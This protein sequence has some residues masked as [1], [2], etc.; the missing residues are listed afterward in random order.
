MAPIDDASLV[1]VSDFPVVTYSGML[2]GVLAGQYDPEQMEIDL[3]RL[4]TVNGARLIVDRVTGIDTVHRELHFAERPALRYDWMSI[5]IGS[6]PTTG[7]VAIN[8]PNQILRIK[9][10]QTFLPRLGEALDRALEIGDENPA[11]NVVGGGVGGIEVALCGWQ[12]IKSIAGS[13][14]RMRIICGS[15]LGKGLL[16]DT[17]RH[18]REQMDQLGIEVFENQRVASVES[19]G[20]VLADGTRLESV[21]SLWATGAEASD[22]LRTINL[23]HDERGFLTTRPT[24]QS[25]DDDRVF[26]VGDSG[27]IQTDRTD[28]AGVFAVRQG[29]VLWRNLRHSVASAPLE[30]YWPQRGYLK[31]INLGDGRAIAEYKGVSLAGRWPWRLKDWIDRRFMAKYQ[32]YRPM[33][34]K[35]A[36][37]RSGDSESRIMRCLGCGGKIG[38]QSLRNVLARLSLRQNDRVLTGLQQADDAAVVRIE[39]GEATVTTDFLAAPFD[40]PFVN[41]R[42]AA[43]NSASD[44]LSM[45]ARPTAALTIAQIPFGHPRAQADVLAELIAG[46]AYEFNLMDV[47]IVGGHTIE[48]PRLVVGFTVFGEQLSQVTRKGNLK[49]GDQIVLTRPLGTGI[50]LAALMQG[51]CRARWYMALLETMLAGNRIALSLVEQFGINAMTDVTGFGLGGHLMEMLDASRLAAELDLDEIPVLPGVD[52]LLAEGIEST[53]APE[54]REMAIGMPFDPSTSGHERILFDPQTAGGLLFG[55]DSSRVQSV[56]EF[57]HSSGLPHSRRIGQAIPLESGDSPCIILPPVRERTYSRRPE[58]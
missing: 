3:V 21:F 9:P 36:K 56:L 24:L 27:T 16:P 53:L 57:L 2:P 12:R 50:L 13:R 29:P 28:K 42:I 51:K 10:M 34:R 47:S 6:R 38:G 32:D 58:S 11:I 41:G 37:E 40:D 7:D 55:V 19:N 44:C 33:E 49:S 26:A 20:V 23:P 4:C 15:G 17:V 31:L 30:E 35:P 48:G 39:G 5:G 45:N 14:F 52:E 46:A 43:L 18:V 25:T 54:N 22:F 1:C 8:D